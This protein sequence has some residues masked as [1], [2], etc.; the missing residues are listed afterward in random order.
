MRNH[1][2]VAL[3]I[4]SA[5]LQAVSYLY[6]PDLGTSADMIGKG[7]I[8]G[9]TDSASAIFENPASLVYVEAKS[10]SAF[11]TT[12]FGEAGYVNCAIAVKLP[13]GTVALG[14]MEASVGGNVHSA[15]ANSRFVEAY[16]YDYKNT[17]IKGAYQLPLNESLS[18]GAGIS[19]Y[20]N[21]L[22]QVSGDGRDLD[23]GMLYQHGPLSVSAYIRNLFAGQ[24]SYSNNQT[25]QLPR[26]ETVSAAYV[27]SWVTGYAQIKHE[28]DQLMPALGISYQVPHMPLE[29]KMGYKTYEVLGSTGSGLVLGTSLVLNG[30][31][32]DYAYEKSSHPSFD[33]HNYFSIAL[34]F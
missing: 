5:P 13:V 30:L 2:I 26:Q 6:I 11:T 20:H 27:W 8:E 28:N 17:V 33:N 19:F 23:I 9:F 22:D 4:I 1:L 31:R 18:I 10:M 34:S 24:V 32:F 3:M 15:E 21:T 29:L 7:N 14:Y 12:I 25:E 16:Q